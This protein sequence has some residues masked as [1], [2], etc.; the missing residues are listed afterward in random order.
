MVFLYQE[1]LNEGSSHIDLHSGE[2]FLSKLKVTD[3]WETVHGPA[4][5]V[6]LWV[7]QVYSTVYTSNF[8]NVHFPSSVQV[9][10]AAYK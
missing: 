6:A 4:L 2:S 9:P 1:F 3:Q 7:A 5:W 10:E 8:H